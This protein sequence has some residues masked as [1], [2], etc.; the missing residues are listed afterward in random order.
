MK[1]EDVAASAEHA[2]ALC[3]EG[4]WR[5]GK[6]RLAEI[7]KRAPSPIN[8][9]SE[10]YAY[11]GY[12]V[13]R[14]DRRVKEGLQLCQHAVALDPGSAEAYLNLAR[15]HL[16]DR[17]RWRASQALMRG[18]QLDPE[19][20]TLRELHFELGVRKNPVLPF[21]SR[22]NPLNVMLGRLRHRLSP[23]EEIPFEDL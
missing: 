21:L 1:L 6:D 23:S 8:L 20:V 14:F 3:R 16:L 9:P 22:R 18:E 19:N 15:V 13:A 7:S 2:V 10:Y 17:N 12:C 11:L 4:R 5:E